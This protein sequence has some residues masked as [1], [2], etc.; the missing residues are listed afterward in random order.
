MSNGKKPAGDKAEAIIETVLLLAFFSAILY[1]GPAAAAQHQIRHDYPVGYA[2][3]DSFQHQARAESIKQMGQYRNEA[4]HIVAGLTDIIGFYPPVLYHTTVLLAHLTGIETYDA[5]MLLIGLAMALG[6][7]AAYYLARSLGKAV[8]VLALP[9]TLFM[10][11]GKPFLGAVTFGQMPFFLSAVFLL[12]TAW[13]LTKINEPKGYVLAAIF[14]AGTIMTHTSETIFIT[15]LFA[16]IMLAAAVAA[17]AKERNIIAGL[18]AA[19][20]DNRQLIFAVGGAAA[21]TLYFIPMFIGIWVKALP[22]KFS[23]E[24]ISASFPAATVFPKDFGLMQYSIVAGIIATA[25]FAIQKRA[26]LGKLL[27]SR[28]FPLLFS[29]YMLI[30]GYGTYAGFGLRSFQLRL[31]WPLF[32]APLAAFG[33]YQAARL[34]LTPLLKRFPK[35]NAYAGYLTYTAIAIILGAAVVA[36]HYEKPSQGSIDKGRWDAMRWLAEN[37]PKDAKAYVL[38]SHVYSQTSSLY[39][40]ERQTYFLELQPFISMINQLSSTGEL[41]RTSYVTIPSDSGPG[42]PYRTGLFSFGRHIPTTKTSDHTDICSAD[43]YL[44]D[45]AFPEPALTQA[46]LYFMQQF[47]K[48]NMTV[49][50]DSPAAAVLRN[51]NKGGNCF[52]Q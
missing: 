15:M 2:A 31:A 47:I 10:A 40:T 25:I 28:L 27:H 7:L 14:L 32:L 48:A 16:G 8:A 26:E 5:L 1:L 46:N 6:A 30:A 13:A 17:T 33:T 9:L 21:I 23:V 12:A 45:K 34:A 20:K 38:Y 3:S 49:E 4:P 35:S 19:V 24:R 51:R 22:Y 44:I 41:N 37:T 36:S 29:A 39:N 52:A 43:Y 50:Y 42:F 18:K 11:T